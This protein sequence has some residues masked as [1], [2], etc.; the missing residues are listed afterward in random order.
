M[1]TY[2][3][4]SRLMFFFWV[5][6]HWDRYR[7][8]TKPSPWPLEDGRGHLIW[9]VYVSACEDL[10][11][12]LRLVDGCRQLPM[13]FFGWEWVDGRRDLLLMFII[14]VRIPLLID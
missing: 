12:F 14:L 6:Q 13:P 1:G 5:T 3:G 10:G 2:F 9:Y 8:A 11:S 4:Q 7:S